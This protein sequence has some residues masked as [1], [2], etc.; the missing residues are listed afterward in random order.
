[1]AR[2]LKRAAA[3]ALAAAACAPALAPR[4]AVDARQLLPS[5]EV[6]GDYLLRQRLGFRRG[7]RGGSVEVVLQVHC[8]EVVLL[9]LAPGGSRLFAIRQVGR[10]I[11]VDA[12]AEERLPFPPEAVLLD[13]HRSFLYPVADPP[14]PDGVHPVSVGAL[15]TRERWAGGRLVERTIPAGSD[16]SAVVIRYEGG[17]AATG[18]PGPVTLEDRRRGYE[19][20]V[21]TLAREALTCAR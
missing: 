9:G 18:I 15:A 10:E 3:L 1:M 17:M 16:A 7:E 12:P 6:A 5:E 4:S 14:L 8:G 11:S 19:L 2:R 21:T 20:R 13:V